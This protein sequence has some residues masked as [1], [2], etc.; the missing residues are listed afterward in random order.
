MLL[1]D[2]SADGVDRR[3]Y[4]G[5]LDQDLRAVPSVFDHPFG[6]FHMSD[7]PRHSVQDFLGMFCRMY[8]TVI[9]L[10]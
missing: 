9:V 7:D 4:G 1:E 2:D 6:G 5:E 3:F 8:V 10:V